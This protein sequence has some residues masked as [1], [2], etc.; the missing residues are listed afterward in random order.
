MGT[1]EVVEVMREYGNVRISKIRANGFWCIFVDL[2][3]DEMVEDLIG[4]VRAGNAETGVFTSIRGHREVSTYYL[5][6]IN[7]TML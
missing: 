1:L 5:A 3:Q 7:T 2:A 4:Q 6:N